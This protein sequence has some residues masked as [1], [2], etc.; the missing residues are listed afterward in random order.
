[1]P[2]EDAAAKIRWEDGD[3][4]VS[5]QFDDPYF[6][7]QDGLAETIHVFL[8]G[9]D[10]TR[11]FSDAHSFS[12]AELGFGTGLNALA[13][14]AL[15]GRAA[16]SGARLTYT[17][18]ELYPMAGDDMARA[19]T[20]WPDLAP[21]ADALLA[22]WPAPEIALPGADLSVVMGD[23]R[24]TVPNWDGTAQ[25]WFLDGFAPSRNPQM[26]EPALLQAVH[27][28]TSPGGTFATYS[29]AGAVR[30]ALAASGFQVARVPGYGRKREM[31]TGSRQD[32][33]LMGR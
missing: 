31:L 15:W 23:A 33:A 28:R 32:P 5:T 19:L 26:W 18:F 13:T 22:S 21:L 11:R 24:Q 14:V 16:P 2:V 3:L 4:P 9:N 29:A 25:A 17:A 1:M 12:I 7:R 27:D 10:L 8:D 20:A 30:R 6:S